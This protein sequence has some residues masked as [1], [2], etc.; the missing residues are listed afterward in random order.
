[1]KRV[2]KFLSLS[3]VALMTLTSCAF[4]AKVMGNIIVN[5]MHKSQMVVNAID[6]MPDGKEVDP[7][8]IEFEKTPTK[9]ENR[10]TL[11]YFK[12]VLVVPHLLTTNVLNTDIV[13]DFVVDADDNQSALNT[14]PLQV[15]NYQ[16]TLT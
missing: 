15:K 6:L 7:K 8:L 11:E 2:S 13:V 16:K 1:M 14:S 5:A 10:A 3:V 12:N 4:V 9:S